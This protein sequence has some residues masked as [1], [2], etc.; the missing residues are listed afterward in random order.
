MLYDIT[1]MWNLKIKIKT[2]SGYSK[3]R[4]RL[5]DMEHKLVSNGEK[6]R[7]TDSIGVGE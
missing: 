3:K 4:N 1:Y 2:T 7:G 5:T 6:E